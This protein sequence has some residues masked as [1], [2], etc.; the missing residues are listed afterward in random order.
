[1]YSLVMSLFSRDFIKT[2]IN[3]LKYQQC[4]S[5]T[6]ICTVFTQRLVFTSILVSIA[7][8]AEQYFVAQKAN[9]VFGALHKVDE[10]FI[11]G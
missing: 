3:K 7:V 11:L 8:L 2:E 10:M 4:F 6:Y 5:L 1:M 9:E